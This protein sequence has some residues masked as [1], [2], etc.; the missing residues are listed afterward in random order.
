M[1]PPIKALVFDVF[2]TVVFSAE[3]FHHYK[4]DPETY[5]GAAGLLGCVPDEVMLVA[6]H[7][8]DLFAAKACGLRTAF[9]R[10]PF[11]YGAA[12]RAGLKSERA[13]DFNVDD[14]NQLAE[15]LCGRGGEP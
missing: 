7:K 8:D 10:R 14:F 2:G 4:P 15:R 13:F 3:T 9:V 11:E 5:L 12:K 1:Q 6:A